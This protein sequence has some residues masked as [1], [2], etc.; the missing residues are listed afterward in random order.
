MKRLTLARPKLQHIKANINYGTD[1]NL[2]D[3]L[4]NGIMY[5]DDDES[6]PTLYS[7]FSNEYS[8]KYLEGKSYDLEG[9]SYDLFSKITLHI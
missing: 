1:A 9:K 8:K 4:N 5:N 6:M 7:S 3:M 2:T